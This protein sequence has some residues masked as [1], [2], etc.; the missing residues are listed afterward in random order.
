MD[1]IAKIWQLLVK[2]DGDT[3]AAQAELRQLQRKTERFGRGM[4]NMGQ[5]L[6]AGVTVPLV[7]FAAVG[8]QE[9]RETMAVTRRTDAVFESMG[10]TMRVTKG[11]LNDLVSE[12]EAYSAIEGDIIQNA[13]NVGLTFSQLAG[14]PELFKQ[15]TRAAVDMSAALGID[16]QQ[17]MTMLG[18]AMQNG[19]KGAAALGRNGTLAK[20]DIAKLQDMAKRGV[21]I[22]KQ[23]QFILKAVNKQY[24]GQGKNV[25]PVRAMSVAVK[26]V[27]EDMAVLLL[28][29]LQSVTGF[30][31][32]LANYVSNLSAQKR[33]W[34]GIVLLVAAALGPLLMIV[35]QVVIAVS[36]LIP[37]IAGLSLPMVAAVAGIAAL[38]AA[39][40]YAY[41]KS[42]EFRQIVNNA[43]LAIKNGA[44]EVFAALQETIAQWVEWAQ[45]IWTNHH[46]T[47]IETVQTM[48]DITVGI[49]SGALRMIKNIILL[50]LALLR[51]DWSAAW[52]AIKNIMVAFWDTIRN[53]AML[54]LQ[55]LK[56][57]LSA[58]WVAIKAA[59]NAAWD[60]ITHVIGAAWNG[61]QTKARETL[62]A[63]KHNIS[64]A[65]G[66]IRSGANSAWG[67]I[68]NVIGRAWNDIQ[69]KARETLNAMQE[70]ISNKWTAINVRAA[71]AWGNFKTNITSIVDTVPGAILGYFDGLGV[72]LGKIGTRAGQALGESLKEAVNAVLA[73]IRSIS[74]PK[75]KIPGT[76]TEIGG[77]QPFGGIRALADGGIVSKPTMA[78]IG[79]AGPEAVIPLGRSTRNVQRRQMVLQQ[80]GLGGGAVVNVYPQSGDPEAIAQRVAMILRSRRVT[81]GGAL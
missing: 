23:Q 10:S 14:N 49:V 33:K 60:G 41:T 39:M 72:E 8:I 69:T 67:A 64:V 9:L 31:Q 57:L 43:F 74:L 62:N 28:P 61:I 51:G 63:I 50:A 24:Q 11:E 78:L 42:D 7:G 16:L 76:D 19:A 4:V 27:A 52:D 15:T 44:M 29:A 6:T 38:V 55:A 18:K 25:D 66:D 58:A 46:D 36:A 26:N 80:S 65:W 32:R 12:L 68:E 59:A 22:W 48:W 17:S 77:G 2:A 3:R 13:A 30:V 20:D 34:L 71:E 53:L 1:D 45:E 75:V 40:V 81:I 35:G 37:V 5:A 79:E 70:R 47:I 56:L 21:P 73:R 54:Q